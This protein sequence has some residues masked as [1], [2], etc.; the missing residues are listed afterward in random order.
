MQQ[1][2]NFKGD[3]YKNVLKNAIDKENCHVG[4][5]LRICSTFAQKSFQV[6]ASWIKTCSN[7]YEM[8]LSLHLMSKGDFFA[9]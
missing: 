1:T 7:F 9:T 8:V 5:I 6:I 4:S 2:R 3:A